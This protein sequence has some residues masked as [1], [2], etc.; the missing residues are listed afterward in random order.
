M[1][2]N[3]IGS[4]MREIRATWLLIVE[5]LQ[6]NG[7]TGWK[8]RFQIHPAMI[9]PF[10]AVQDREQQDLE[11][12]LE[13]H[14]RQVLNLLHE[15]VLHLDEVG[16]VA[17]HL[18]RVGQRHAQLGVPVLHLGELLRKY[19]QHGQSAEIS[20]PPVLFGARNFLVYFD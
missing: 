5:E 20:A 9:E 15:V 19:R 4:Q 6:H 17:E 2:V 11:A 1:M 14:V 8:E 18:V 7:L 16:V 3:F 13:N 10:T 12:V